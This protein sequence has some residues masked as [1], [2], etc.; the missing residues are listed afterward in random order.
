M[1]P[2]GPFYKMAEFGVKALSADE[3]KDPAARIRQQRE[4]NERLPLELLGN[5]GLI[6]L[7]RDI[8]SLLL[9]D[10]YKGMGKDK[11]G[12]STGMTKAEKAQ[13]KE[14]FPEMYEMQ[15]QLEEDMKNPELE[16]MMK[17]QEKA[18]EEMMKGL[19]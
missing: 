3:K 14:Y 10:I 17:E 18:I 11:K 13:M 7:Y 15:M 12:S 1:G 6:P 16:R 2:F 9:A 5:L 19:K 8:R 4:L